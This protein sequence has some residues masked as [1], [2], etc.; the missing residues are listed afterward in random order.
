M[1]NFTRWIVTGLL[2]IVMLCV[3][4]LAAFRVAAAMREQGPVAPPAQGRM[5]ETGDGAMFVQTRG[6][7]TGAPVMLVHGTAAWSGFW[8]ETAD[9][10][11]ARGFRVYAIDIPPF[12]FSSRSPAG[13]YARA[14]QA[15]RIGEAI[16]ALKLKNVLIVGHSFGAGAVTEAV[17]RN[18]KDFAGMVLI[19][20]AL[21]LPDGEGGYPEDNGALR[22]LI[23]Q[24]FVVEPLVAATF[25]N[26][27]LTRRFLAMMLHRTEA[28]T[29]LQAAILQAPQ[30]REGT[31]ESYARWLPL[32]LFP[33]RA[34]MSA[35]PK[36]YAAIRVPTALIWGRQDSVT[37]LPQGERLQRLIVG[38]SLDVIEDAGHI[39][40]IEAPDNLVGVLAERLTAIGRIK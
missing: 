3:L 15:R 19:C 28:A 36:N 35:D 21:G 5:V 13:T 14:D 9:A 37:P 17:M 24:P 16:R 33:D 18:P 39:P 10:L 4:V 26:P 8:S 22:W 7:E 29:S 34:A 32:L 27:L 20:G 40:H 31:T 12:G 11:A 38:S 25:T 23:A 2:A 30:R 1:R 6:P